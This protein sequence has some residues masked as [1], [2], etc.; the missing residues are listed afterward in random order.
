MNKPI[1]QTSGK[2]RH[3]EDFSVLQEVYSELNCYPIVVHFDKNAELAKI[4]QEFDKTDF[5]LSKI[6]EKRYH[7]FEDEIDISEYILYKVA[8][9]FYLELNSGEESPDSFDALFLEEDAVF[10]SSHL[11]LL[12]PPE[13]HKLYNEKQYKEIIK[14]LASSK[15]EYAKEQ[16]SIKMICHDDGFFLRDFLI[17]DHKLKDAD[18]HYGKGFY[19]FHEKIVDKLTNDKKGL[20]L[21]HG[22]PGTGKTFYIRCLLSILASSNKFV[23]YIPPGM[24]GYITSPEL[25]THIS[26]MVSE[27][28]LDDKQCIILLEDADPLLVSRNGLD[29]T[30]GITNLLNMTDGLLNDMLDIQVIATF[31]TN[32]TSLDSAL[33]RPERLAA[34]KEFKRLTVQ[35]TNIL[36][37][38]LGLE[39]T[40]DAKTLAQIY[41][42]S[43]KHETILHEYIENKK[44]IGFK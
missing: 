1:E 3:Y 27:K 25:M 35:D 36:Q 18:L 34:R 39:E 15:L 4:I 28:R 38:H 24:I 29:R 23:L 43:N 5:K 26:D 40:K 32:L 6:F 33:L 41:S 20:F 2:S 19:E 12:I 9:S 16:A 30:E 10:L 21:L 7:S 13:N 42:T 31:N 17:G 11:T 8:P 14:V 37:K 22:E 44:T